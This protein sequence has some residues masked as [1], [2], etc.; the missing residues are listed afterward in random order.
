MS[1]YLNSVI[2]PELDETGKVKLSIQDNNG[3]VKLSN[4]SGSVEP[5]T[6]EEHV[7]ELKGMDS[8]AAFFPGTGATGTGAVSSTPL[9]S[10]AGQH[11]ISREDAKNP[12]KYR[13]AKEAAVKAGTTLQI[14]ET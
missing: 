1:Y 8:F 6:V 2:K 12:Q 14:A 3:N 5:M 10:K 9:R 11:I 13:V 4:K 7:A